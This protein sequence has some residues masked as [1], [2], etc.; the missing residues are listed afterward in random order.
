MKVVT[1]IGIIF[2]ERPA[3]RLRNSKTF[4]CSS[5]NKASA[6]S[7]TIMTCS[8]RTFA[9]SGLSMTTE[10]VV[11]KSVDRIGFVPVGWK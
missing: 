3:F 1:F 6:D 9:N 8:N 5:S 2:S 7:G 10:K 11:G 4:F